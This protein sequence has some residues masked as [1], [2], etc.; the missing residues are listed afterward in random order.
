MV[1]RL[2]CHAEQCR[3]AAGQ[4]STQRLCP[5]L[6]ERV[7]HVPRLFCHLTKA[8]RYSI[9]FRLL[10]DTRATYRRTEDNE[11]TDTLTVGTLT[12]LGSGWLTEGDALLANT[13]AQQRRESRRIGREELA[14]EAG[15]TGAAA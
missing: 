6:A 3:E 7:T 9:T 11:P 13:A 10:R 12:Y 2:Q 14:H 15:L 5:S 8:R 1:V 4:P